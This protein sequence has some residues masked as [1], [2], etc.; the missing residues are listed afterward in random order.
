MLA[1]RGTELHVVQVVDFEHFTLRLRGQL[2]PRD[3]AAFADDVDQDVEPAQ[4]GGRLFDR[5]ACGARLT[6]V[7]GDAGGGQLAGGR[8]DSFRIGIEHTY[9]RTVGGEQTRRCAAHAESTTHYE[10]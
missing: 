8:L 5:I 3:V 1:E 6:Y 7:R 10:G 4:L 9:P 2:G